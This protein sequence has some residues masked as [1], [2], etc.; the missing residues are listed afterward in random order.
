[1]SKKTS[2]PTKDVFLTENDCYVIEH[3]GTKTGAEFC[4]ELNIES[5]D[6]KGITSKLSKAWLIP[7]ALVKKKIEAKARLEEAKA[8]KEGN[9]Y[10][11]SNGLNKQLGR[12]IVV[13]EIRDSGIVGTV[14]SLPFEEC[15]FEHQLLDR[16]CKEFDFVGVEEHRQTYYNLL[17]TVINDKIKMSCNLGK[18]LET[19]KN[20]KRDQY[21]HIFADFCGQADSYLEDIK[22]I[23]KNKLVQVGGTIAITFT[24]R[25]S[26][27][28]SVIRVMNELNPIGV[29]KG[30]AV[31][32]GVLT[33]LNK[34]SK[35]NYAIVKTFSYKDDGQQ[36]MVLFVLK[37]VK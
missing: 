30:N 25:N 22:L 13:N 23:I 9:V 32:K 1:M 18:F 15:I 16:V 8:K 12:D 10:T 3:Y 11:N 37:R 5:K 7:T 34:I 27:K 29:N 31:E 21:A 4:E 6:Y 20:S 19:V 2:E 14:L 26:S 35:T 36:G 28:D 24:N 33:Y 17:Q